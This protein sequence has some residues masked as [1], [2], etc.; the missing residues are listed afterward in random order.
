[1]INPLDAPMALKQITD[2]VILSTLSYMRKNNFADDVIFMTMKHS[3][4]V[5]KMSLEFIE[6]LSE[7][8]KSFK[9]LL[10]IGKRYYSK[11][12]TH[13]LAN[14]VPYMAD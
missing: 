7:E 12:I 10:H 8:N 4:E 9:D 13:R 11:N 1:M 6:C 5:Q 3:R 2:N 14:L